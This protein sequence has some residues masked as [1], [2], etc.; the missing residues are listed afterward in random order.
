MG[1]KKTNCESCKKRRAEYRCEYCEALY[2]GKCEKELWGECETC[3]PPRLR[4][5]TTKKK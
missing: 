5:I 1:R 4:E 2:C 3:E